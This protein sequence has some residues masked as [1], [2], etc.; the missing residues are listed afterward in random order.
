MCQLAGVSRAGFYRSSQ[1]RAPVE[2]EM[3]ARLA[4]QE[5]AVEHRRRYVGIGG[6]TAELR[7]RGMAVNHKRVLRILGED[8][9]LAV[10]RRE[11]VA[12]TDSD[13]RFPVH[14]NLARRSWSSTGI[15]QLWV[16]DIT[17]LRLQ[18]EFVYLGGGALDAF[19]APGGGMG[20]AAARWPVSIA[21]RGA[22]T[23]HR[24]ATTAAGTRASLRSRRAVR[25]RRLRPSLAA[26]CGSSRA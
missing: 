21:D 12:T 8:N 9:L 17:Y 24:R 14:L 13:H 19:I 4:I 11:F 1:E 22:G 6:I 3:Q 10:R 16:S 2:E 15:N 7:R 20:A 26:A 5:I 23:G 18:N 25:V